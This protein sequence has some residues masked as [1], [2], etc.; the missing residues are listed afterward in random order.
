MDKS[1]CF[2]INLVSSRFTLFRVSISYL[3]KLWGEKRSFNINYQSRVVAD[4]I[5]L[6][7]YPVCLSLNLSFT[8][9]PNNA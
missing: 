4:I 1:E 2:L 6:L 8:E 9:Y 5:R 3:E 7:D